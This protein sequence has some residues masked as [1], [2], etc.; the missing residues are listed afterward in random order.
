MMQQVSAKS[1]S[2]NNQLVSSAADQR[3]NYSPTQVP[4]TTPS[5]TS[6]SSTLKPVTINQF[7]SLIDQIA[8]IF[9]S[10]IKVLRLFF[11]SNLQGEI[12]KQNNLYAKQVTG[13][14]E[15][16]KWHA[17]IEV[18]TAYI[19]G[20]LHADGH[21][22]STIVIVKTMCVHVCVCADVRVWR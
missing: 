15:F 5:P 22:P 12:V 20:V 9:E 17:K 1:F 13:D 10:P 18:R 4:P 21:Q 6:W 3:S 11:T 16:Q 2:H 7:T 8:T 14:D 19:L